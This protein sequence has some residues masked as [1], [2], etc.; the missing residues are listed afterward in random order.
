MPSNPTTTIC[1]GPWSSLTNFIHRRK[2]DLRYEVV[3]EQQ[4]LAHPHGWNG[5]YLACAVVML[6]ILDVSDV[7]LL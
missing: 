2:T 5:G 3:G 1:L 4:D 7:S 6:T